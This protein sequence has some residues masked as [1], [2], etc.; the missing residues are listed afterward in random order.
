MSFHANAAYQALRMDY[1]KLCQAPLDCNFWQTISSLTGR[2]ISL[3]VDSLK[4]HVPELSASLSGVAVCCTGSDSRLEKCGLGSPFECIVITP[5]KEIKPLQSNTV[6]KIVKMCFEGKPFFCPMVE[7]KSLDCDLVSNCE[8]NQGPPKVIPT[9]A[10]DAYFLAGD[11]GLFRLYKH[12][13]LDEL[14]QRQVDL[15]MFRDDFLKASLQSLRQE[16]TGSPR[17]A[18]LLTLDSGMVFYDKNG[19]RGLKHDALRAVQYSLADMI[20]KSVQEGRLGVGEVATIPQTVIG[21]LEWF[22]QKK[23][24][25]L[26]D[27]EYA[28]L[29]QHYTRVSYWYALLNAKAIEEPQDLTTMTLDPRELRPVLQETHDLCRKMRE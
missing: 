13:V 28:L 6:G 21:R 16:L 25:P 24:S 9:R 2:T 29:K 22:R 15:R 4:T 11:E 20:F 8:V 26:S 5:Q 17:K 7:Q 27:Q 1:A 12:K 14:S 18:P 23:M 19:R 3:A 10:F